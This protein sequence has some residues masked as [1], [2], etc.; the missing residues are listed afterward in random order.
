MIEQG[1]VVDFS[2]LLSKGYLEDDNWDWDFEKCDWER[3]RQCL[4][5]PITIRTTMSV[6]MNCLENND[7]EHAK[8]RAFQYFRMILEPEYKPE[9]FTT[10][11]LE[12]PSWMKNA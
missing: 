6:F 12:E 1:T 10:Q 2:L 11:E 5:D 9:P 4:V 7:F 3:Y 8:Y